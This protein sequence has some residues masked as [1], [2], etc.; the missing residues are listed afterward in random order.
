MEMTKQR[1]MLVGVLCLGIG[2]LAVDRFVLGAP[3]TASA[4]DEVITAQA[5]LETEPAAEQA[6]EPGAAGGSIK[7]LP[8]YS[9]LTQRLVQAQEQAGADPQAGQQDDPFALPERWRV[10]E[11]RPI[12]QAAPDPVAKTHRISTL[13]RLD[14]TVSTSIDG[15]E[16]MLAVISGGGLEGRAIRVGQKVRVPD[17]NGSYDIYT[18][19]RVGSRLVVWQPEGTQEEIIMRVEEVL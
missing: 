19:I 7:A 16:E 1:K 8:S 13:F 18:L 15:K 17:G 9:S 10:E 14:G 3:E 4:D 6:P 2:G 11:S 12:N 5:P